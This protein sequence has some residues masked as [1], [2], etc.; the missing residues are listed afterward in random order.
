MEWLRETQWLAWIGGA[1]VLGLVEVASLDLVFVMLA[2]AALVS[3]LAAFLGA[4]FPIQVIVFVLSSVLLL[5]VARPIALRKLKPAGPGERTGT[6]GQVGRSAEVLTAVTGRSGM[7]KLSGEHWTAR[8][9]DGTTTF[10]IGEVVLV[11][12]IDGA[13]AVVERAPGTSPSSQQKENR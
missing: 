2:L 13:T 7:V 4:S 1:L 12:Q 5:A 10:E 3:A 6:A 11:V 8:S 9:A